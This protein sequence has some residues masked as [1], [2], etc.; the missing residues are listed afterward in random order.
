MAVVTRSISKDKYVP[1]LKGLLNDCEANYLRFVRLL[2]TL[3]ETSEWI[4]A[5]ELPS[6]DLS[7]VVISVVERSRYTTTISLTQ[8]SH[9]GEWVPEPTIT[10][11]LYHD[12]RVAEVLSYQKN[13]RIKQ[14]YEYPNRDM[15]HRNEKAQLNA[16]LGEWLDTCLRFGCAFGLPFAN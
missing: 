8:A 10:V 14:S 4:F 3:D 11:R 12:A 16:F 7:R 2:P 5:V 13:Q 1:D 9:V 15:Y 6:E